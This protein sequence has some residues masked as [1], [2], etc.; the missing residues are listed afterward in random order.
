MYKT[1][2]RSVNTGS[3]EVIINIIDSIF[4]SIFDLASACR[5]AMTTP[6]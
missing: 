6:T 3:T 4:D 5:F 1:A 2:L